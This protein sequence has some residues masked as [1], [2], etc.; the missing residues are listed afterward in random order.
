MHSFTWSGQP[1][2][3]KK[4]K[5]R[6][7]WEFVVDVI[8]KA[9][10]ASREVNL[11]L[12]VKKS[13][14]EFLLLNFGRFNRTLPVQEQVRDSRGVTSHK[15]HK[16]LTRNRL[17]SPSLSTIFKPPLLLQLNCMQMMSSYS[18]Y[19]Y[20]TQFYLAATLWTI[21]PG[22]SEAS[23]LHENGLLTGEAVSGHKNKNSHPSS[24]LSSQSTGRSR[25]A[26]AAPGRRA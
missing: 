10:P 3:S 17:S 19:H 12:P 14:R 2:M 13:K 26:S 7:I 16:D 9:A 25:A 24:K 6:V 18:I 11:S 21:S 1:G 8:P 22:Y 20:Y 4:R 15:F 5:T 23:E